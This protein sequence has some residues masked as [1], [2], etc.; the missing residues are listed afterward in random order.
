VFVAEC[1]FWNGEK[2]Y[3]EAIDQLINYL[4][5][6]DT[7]TSLI[8]FVRQKDFSVVLE[9]IDGKTK[10]H[11]NYLGRETKTDENWFNFRFHLNGDK[12][13][14]TKMAVQLYHLPMD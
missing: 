14:E 12:S 1:K 5:W 3:F 10:D 7:K 11:S 4:T 6:R 9:K 13:R 2:S 8:L